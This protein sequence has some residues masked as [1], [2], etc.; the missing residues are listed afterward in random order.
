MSDER[1]DV[2]GERHE[3]K[4]ECWEMRGDMRDVEVE[5]VR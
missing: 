3:L 5:G 4:G 1:W 2:G